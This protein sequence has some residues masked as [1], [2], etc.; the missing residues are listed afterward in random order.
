V[1]AGRRDREF[2]AEL[3]SHL[4]MHI[5]DNMRSGMTAD[6]A[7]RAAVVAL[8]GIEVAKEEYRDRA[9]V[10]WIA[11]L[12]RDVRYGLRSLRK[13]PGFTAGATIVLALGVGANS[14]IFSVI[15]ATLLRP[16]PIRDDAR[17]A[18]VWI[19]NRA[20]GR[21][22][23]GPTGQD[24]LDWMQAATPFED[25]FL[26]E[27]G[28]GT[29]TGGAEPEQVKGLRVTT[30]FADFLGVKPV[31]G[32]AFEPADSTRNVILLSQG[33]WTRR[34]SADPGVL[35]RS[36]TLN[37]D[38]YT[39]IGV[40]PADACFWYPPDVVVAWP[41]DRLRRADSNLGV[42]G[43]L[44][45]SA[46]F[47]IAQAQMDAVA[48]RIAEERPNDR[49]DWG[50]V[51]VPLRDVTVQYVRPAL[52]VLLGAVGC[53]LLI[54]CANV[55]GL[56][57]VRTLG[58]QKEIAVRAAL[59][60]GRGRL[61]QQFLVESVLIGVAGGALG[62]LAAFW[63]SAALGAIMPASIPVPAAA[64]QVPL[65]RGRIDFVVFGYAFLVSFVTSLAFGLG[66]VLICLRS[67]PAGSLNDGTRTSG[68][69]AGIGR[70]RAALIVTEAALAVVLLVGSGLMVKSFWNLLN[71]SPGFRPAELMTLQIKLA[72]EGERS[73]Y[74]DPA[75]R[76]ASMNAFLAQ[77]RAVPGIRS[78]ALAQILPLSQDDQNVGGFVVAERPGT[79]TAD[80][81]T[82]EF[83]IVT[84]GYFETM[85]I[86]LRAG[87][88]LSPLDAA[89]SPRVVVIDETLSRICCGSSNAVGR[90]LQ[91]P[92]AAGAPREIVGVVG[93]VLDDSL[94]QAA[95]PTIYVPYPQAPAQMMS[96]VMRTSANAEAIVPAVKHAIWGVDP[97][98]PLFNVRRMPDIV[99]GTISAN[100]L[101]FILLAVF[102]GIA[103]VLATV[104]IY[105]VTSFA[106][107][108][109][110]HEIGLR[111]ALGASRT[112]VLKLVV[113]QGLRH[114]LIGLL[115]GLA[116]AAALSQALS[117]L[118]FGVVP[119]DARTFVAVGVV[120]AAVAVL[121]NG[122]PAWRAANVRPLDALSGR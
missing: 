22:R 116:A 111:L 38:L 31:L 24:Y 44:K 118:L 8:G 29:I 35:G 47:A 49:K 109:R 15:H 84:A 64:S 27:H 70:P 97:D 92:D 81:F 13:T 36:L 87:R 10:P 117:S 98:Q 56:L 54:A 45:P 14:A 23:V 114:A 51:V 79:A 18:V 19:D 50:I 61:I 67:Q 112:D 101:A 120:F 5:A 122:V 105:G 121:A 34:F 39:V 42:F 33:Y 106:V 95:R 113:G 28:S 32:R 20:M 102:A 43:R 62:L 11:S 86:P 103:L 30:N 74:H 93:S 6:E 2:G 41:P 107:K 55:G 69:G 58:R 63:G 48:A 96:L 76:T 53:V 3:D 80:R 82:G 7:R 17:V 52:L 21:S 115:V 94:D 88:L 66:P 12:S 100:R 68:A 57:V 59:G 26:F 1:G 78:A 60:A 46:T 104:G 75:A 110:T 99:A 90:H 72:D 77:V 16:L 40:L 91:I 83:R 89:A 65:P 119:L 25:L 73:K 108:Q 37:G 71:V 9:G 85:N 4:Q